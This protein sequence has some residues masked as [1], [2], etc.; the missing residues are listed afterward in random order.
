MSL[1]CDLTL[2]HLKQT[3]WTLVEEA[4]GSFMANQKHDA[5][6]VL[7]P[8]SFACVCVGT[9]RG[10]RA[11]VCHSLDRHGDHPLLFLHLQPPQSPAVPHQVGK[12]KKFCLI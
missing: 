8:S 4:W 9:K 5:S 7:H 3:A 12:V 2:K 11:A 1:L 6:R 10:Q